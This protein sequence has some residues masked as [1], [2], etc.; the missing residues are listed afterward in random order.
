MAALGAAPNPVPPDTTAKVDAVF[1]AYDHSDSPGCALAVIQDGSIVYERG[2]G[3]ANLEL[4]VANS[5]QSVFDIAS[6]GKQF[7]AFSIHLLARDGK[8]SLDDDIRKWVPEIPSYGK[9]ITIRH[10]LHH[11]SGLRDYLELMSLQGVR[12]EDISTEQEALDV[13]ALQKALNF[14]P[15]AEHLYCNSGYFLLGIIVKRA[16][17]KSLR[18]FAEERIFGPL[19]MRHTQYN[20]RH[21][22]IIPNRAT[23]YGK[24]KTL[25]FGIDMSDFEQN[26]DGGVLTSVEDLFR[27]D[28]NFYDPKVGDRA[29]IDA[30]LVDG[31][32]N[33]GKPVNYSSALVVG[34]YKGLPTVAHSGSWAGYRSQLIRFP[35]QRFSVV[36]LCNLE[37]AN[38][39]GLARQVAEVYLGGLMKQPPPSADEAKAGTVRPAAPLAALEKLSGPYRNGDTGEVLE[40]AVKEGKLVAES[41]EYALGSE[42]DHRQ[43]LFDRGLYAAGEQRGGVRDDGWLHEAPDDRDD[44]GRRWGDRARG[45]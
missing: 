9:T 32:L 28:Q 18:D 1:A 6:M 21:E 22:R 23:G 29:L 7:T 25:G 36:C 16:S 13:L 31:V 2:Y 27:W 42:T 15:G 19:G 30:M 11:T 26:G 35:Q 12:D 40:L 38:A 44:P 45:L 14:E 33:N 24:S 8:L 5:P 43:P 3:M 4:G 17:G 37:Q 20:D 34:S 39:T 41:A 10:L